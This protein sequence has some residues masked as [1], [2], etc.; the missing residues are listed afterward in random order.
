MISALRMLCTNSGQSH[1][2]AFAFG[3]LHINKYDLVRVSS[4]GLVVVNKIKFCGGGISFSQASNISIA[5][6]FIGIPHSGSFCN[7]MFYLIF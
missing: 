2:P 1:F 6:G 4:I 7:E 3:S 5:D